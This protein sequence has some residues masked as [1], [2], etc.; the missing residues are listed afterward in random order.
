MPS[1][2]RGHSGSQDQGHRGDKV[3]V[4][5]LDTKNMQI[6]NEYFRTR[7]E[8]E[9]DVQSDRQAVRQADGQTKYH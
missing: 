5:V 2:R 4:I 9:K 6:R 1:P 8:F 3:N 7:L